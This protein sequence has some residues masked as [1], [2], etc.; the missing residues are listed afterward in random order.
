MTQRHSDAAAMTTLQLT[1]A[2]EL[3]INIKHPRIK[4]TR[5]DI[6][7]A[8]RK[9]FKIRKYNKIYIRQRE[10]RKITY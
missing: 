2:K 4:L 6:Y 3:N 5:Q 7:P 10:L 9:Y 8:V 1:K